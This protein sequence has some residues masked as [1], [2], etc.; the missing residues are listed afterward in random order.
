M[1]RINGI[2]ILLLGMLLISVSLMAQ[3]VATEPVPGM[4]Y[5]GVFA[6]LVAI[7]AAVPFVVEVVKG[8]FPKMNAIV[9]QILSWVV[10]VALC[11]FGWWQHLGFLDGLDWYI[12]LLYGLGS[13]LAA[14]GIADIGLVQWL[15]SLF[16]RKKEPSKKANP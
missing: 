10:A 14:N 1:K 15:I 3:E 9:T 13:G 6:S 12:A 16:T 8:F 11:M 7:V 4:D 2:F 5:D